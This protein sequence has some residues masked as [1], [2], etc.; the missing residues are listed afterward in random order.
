[1]SDDLS[2]DSRF[3]PPGHPS[4]RADKAPLATNLLLVVVIYACTMG[5]PLILG[6]AMLNEMMFIAGI[7]HLTLAAIFFVAWKGL[8]NRKRWAGRMAIALATLGVIGPPIAIIGTVTNGTF[9]SSLLAFPG[10]FLIY[11]ATLLWALT[12]PSVVVRLAGNEAV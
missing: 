7:V 4:R 11:F 2:R 9:E 1:M 8:L 12:R 5:V 3:D 6:G 10:L